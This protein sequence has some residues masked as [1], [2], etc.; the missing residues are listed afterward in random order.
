MMEIKVI[1]CFLCL[2]FATKCVCNNNNNNYQSVSLVEPVLDANRPFTHAM[3]APSLA[4][5]VPARNLPTPQAEQLE[6]ALADHLPAM[7]FVHLL[8][9][10]MR[11]EIGSRTNTNK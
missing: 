3:Q 8:A 9:P 5:P 10:I 6:L 4:D 1:Y 11:I 2:S 7:H